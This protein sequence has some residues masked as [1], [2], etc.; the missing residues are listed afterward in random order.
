MSDR[1]EGAVKKVMDAVGS[2]SAYGGNKIW[3][4]GPLRRIV[5]AMWE[6]A[7]V[8]KAGMAGFRDAVAAKDGNALAQL[9][10]EAAEIYTKARPG[11]VSY[12]GADA[13]TPW[14]R[15]PPKR[16]AGGGADG[17]AGGGAGGGGGG[18]GWR[19]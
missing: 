7:F 15:F 3:V 4:P 17:K 5:G 12:P 1:K 11:C 16:E 14:S 2:H 8:S 13:F 10:V 18:D 6:S 19:V 9:A